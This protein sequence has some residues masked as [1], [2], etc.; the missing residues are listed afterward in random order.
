MWRAIVESGEWSGVLCR[1]P[2]RLNGSWSANSRLVAGERPDTAVVLWRLRRF[3]DEAP[4]RYREAFESSPTAILF[5]DLD[6]RVIEVNRA[7]CDL[8]GMPDERS[9]LADPA[10]T[11]WENAPTPAEIAE[12]VARGEGWTGEIRARRADGGAFPAQLFAA[13]IDD[14]AGEPSMVMMTV[15]DLTQTLRT[16]EEL[17]A[18]RERLQLVLDAAPVVLWA[19]D[20][21]GVFTLSEGRELRSI[22]LAPGQVVGRSLFNLYADVPAAVSSAHR[23]LAGESFSSIGEFGPY[24]YESRHEPLRDM[25]GNVIGTMGV[26][27]NITERKRAEAALARVKESLDNAQRIAKLGNWD[28]IPDTDLVWWSDEIYRL[29][30]LEI[31]AVTPGLRPFMRFV[32]DEDR[33]SLKKM[34]GV[35]L[36]S[37]EPWTMEHRLVTATGREIVVRHWTEVV[38]DERGKPLR[39]RGVFQ[40]ITEVRRLEREQE[41]LRA[42]YVQSQ[43]LDSV[44]RLAGGVAHDFNNLITTVRGYADL[45]LRDSELAG[46]VREYVDEIRRTADRAAALSRRLLAF[47]RRE[48]ANPRVLEVD[49]AIEDAALMVRRLIGDDIQLETA[50]AAVDAGILIDPIHLDQ[51]VINLAVNARDALPRG[52]RIRVETGRVRLDAPVGVAM[53]NFVPGEYVRLRVADSGTGIAPEHLDKIFEPFFTTKDVG[54]GTG[55]GLAT[56]YGLVAQS[57]GMIDVTSR[58]GVGTTFVIHWPVATHREAP[59]PEIQIRDVRSGGRILLV[60]DEDG[61][62]RLTSLMLKSLGF[63]V[64]EAASGVEVLGLGAGGLRSIDLLM[65]DVVMPYMNGRE[66][67]EKLRPAMP[68]L[69]VLYVSGYPLE[70]VTSYG[71]APDDGAFLGKPF[72]LESLQSKLS[73]YFAPGELRAGRGG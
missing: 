52:G 58:L 42:L 14:A 28:W 27:V 68:E 61:L 43:K 65:T 24:T 35:S 48:N 69:R 66:L 53:P 37:E 15:F 67:Y 39:L 34:I 46:G 8:W 16:T 57:R 70:V 2:P 40:D 13:A 1:N 73:A 72:T 55:L 5:T 60:E 64:T 54:E 12:R 4:R 19:T 30:D 21:D 3:R 25:E 49:S 26:A 59:E 36:A 63:C 23:C 45:L 41:G 17:R 22:G 31:G 56:V 38:R 29:L 11:L 20:K 47:S 10:P 6:G 50:L 51:I 7:F 32:H 9:A 33:E 62:R 44:G 71:I 18:S